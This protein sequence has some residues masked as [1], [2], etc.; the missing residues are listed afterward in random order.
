MGFWNKL[1]K[2]EQSIRRRIENAFG[3]GTADTPL[4]LRREII[5]QIESRIAIDAAGNLF[6][7]ATVTIQLYP[8]TEAQRDVFET[9]FLRDASLKEE[10]IEKLKESDANYPEN[11]EITVDVKHP[12]TAPES[13]APFQITFVKPEPP[14]EREVPEVKL[15]ITKGAAD[16]PVYLMK[17]ERILI[18]RLAEV[19][20]REGRMVR[21]NDVA[22]LDNRDEI[23]STVGRAHARIWYD[24]EK[25]EFRIVDEVSRYGT[26]I[27]R[28]GRSL[29]VPG[30]NPRGIRL[31]SGD[32]IYLGQACIRFEQ[33]M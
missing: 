10:V 30:G 11:L 33:V 16:H 28:G 7:Y 31:C 1:L 4:E 3:Y 26:Q 6:P 14:R 18:G 5:E 2:T 25:P 27:L 8:R 23:N 13:S 22:F 24:F 12:A 19:L 29:E 32:D 20:D 21:R 15:I 9:A 17:K